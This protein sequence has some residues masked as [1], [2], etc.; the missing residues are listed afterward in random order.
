[1]SRTPHAGNGSGINGRAWRSRYFRVDNR[2]IYY[3][4]SERD[5]EPLGQ[6][7]LTYQSQVEAEGPEVLHKVRED[8]GAL[9]S[10]HAFVVPDVLPPLQ[11][12]AAAMCRRANC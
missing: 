6:F 3:F 4:K 5:T 12:H 10:V 8:S 9:L 11:P 1:M 7:S 2:H